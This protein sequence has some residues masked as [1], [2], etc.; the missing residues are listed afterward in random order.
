M[1]LF[2]AGCDGIWYNSHTKSTRGKKMGDR[3]NAASGAGQEVFKKSKL[4]MKDIYNDV[5][6]V[7]RKAYEKNN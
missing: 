1:I 3:L 4:S 5:K 6:S 7:R 2:D